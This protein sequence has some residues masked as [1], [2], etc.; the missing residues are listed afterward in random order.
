MNR[1][2]NILYKYI[3]SNGIHLRL[4]TQILC[5]FLLRFLIICK[6]I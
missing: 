6:I 4:K 3:K 1:K 5:F 2:Q